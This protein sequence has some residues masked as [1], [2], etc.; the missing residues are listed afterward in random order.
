MTSVTNGISRGRQALRRDVN[1]RISEVG[2]GSEAEVVEV[3]CEC[4]HVRCADRVRIA[5]EAYEQVRT[6]AACFV[7]RSGH[8]ETGADQLVARHNGYVVVERKSR[9]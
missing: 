6:S 8:E 3:F 2:A 5:T 1:K 4:G 7:V 9:R